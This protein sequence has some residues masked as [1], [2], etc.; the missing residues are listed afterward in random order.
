M[1]DEL[2]EDEKRKRRSGGDID[3]MLDDREGAAVSPPDRDAGAELQAEVMTA[4]AIERDPWNAVALDIPAD[5]SCELLY[6]A[7][8]AARDCRFVLDDRAEEAESPEQARG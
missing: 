3:R 6:Q 8:T 1:D 4:E 7:A 2:T 5:A